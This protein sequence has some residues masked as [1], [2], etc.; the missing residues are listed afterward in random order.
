MTASVITA[1]YVFANGM[2][3]VF[4]QF[5]HQMPDYQGVWEEVKEKV[6]RD[7]PANVSVGHCSWNEFKRTHIL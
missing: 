7:K 4:D 3:M 2:A 6:M 5:G 1:V